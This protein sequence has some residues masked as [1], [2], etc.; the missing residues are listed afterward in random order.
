MVDLSYTHGTICRYNMSKISEHQVVAVSLNY[1]L[2]PFGFIAFDEMIDQGNPRGNFGMMDIASGLRWVQREISRFGGD[3][4]RV[5]IMGQSS[6]GQGAEVAMVMPMMKGLFRGVISEST[7][8]G[9]VSLEYAQ[10]Q[11]RMLVKQLKCNNSSKHPQQSVV[12]CM[13]G[14]KVVKVV[15]VIRDFV[16][17][18]SI[19]YY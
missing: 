1:R 18:C 9:A 7:G 8:M 16:Q 15:T 17:T 13:K 10:K 5:T 3:P 11:T 6:A 2:G 4:T 19:N 12:E 14:H